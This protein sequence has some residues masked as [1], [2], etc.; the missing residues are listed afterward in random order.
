MES[1]SKFRFFPKLTYEII[2]ADSESLFGQHLIL[3]PFQSPHLSIHGIS[4]IISDIYF[5]GPSLHGP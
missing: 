1:W 4:L 5:E 3:Q 2:L